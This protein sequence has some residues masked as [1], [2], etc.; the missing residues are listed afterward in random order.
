MVLEPDKGELLASVSYPEPDGSTDA[1]LDRAR[2][3]LYP[4]GSTFK[5]VTASTALREHVDPRNTI[6]TCARDRGARRLIHP[7]RDS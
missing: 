2:Y 5:L 7:A 3:G 4:P 6:F 1:L